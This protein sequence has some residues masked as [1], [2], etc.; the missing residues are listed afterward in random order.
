MNDLSKEELTR[1]ARENEEFRRLQAAAISAVPVA[2]PGTVS[3]DDFID[4][5]AKEITKFEIYWR[6]KWLEDPEKY[7]NHLDSN[8]DWIE[9]FNAWLELTNKK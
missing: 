8:E 1:I 4:Y 6:S 3:K 9:Q 7:P 5:F 2:P